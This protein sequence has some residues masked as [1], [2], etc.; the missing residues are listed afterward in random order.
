MH[1]KPRGGRRTVPTPAFVVIPWAAAK[2]HKAYNQG[3]LIQ[4]R[5]TINQTF[6]NA[7]TI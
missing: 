4:L 7:L 5:G 6:M 3:L 2:P 1:G